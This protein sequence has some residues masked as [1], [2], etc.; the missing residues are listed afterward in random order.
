MAQKKSTLWM[1][2][3]PLF[4]SPPQITFADRVEVQPQSVRLVR[5][6]KFLSREK[7][8]V[9]ANGE[10]L[11]TF[12]I[13]EGD[14]KYPSLEHIKNFFEL[15]IKDAVKAD[16]PIVIEKRSR[17]L[18]NDVVED[19]LGPKNPNYQHSLRIQNGFYVAPHRIKVTQ[20]KK[21]NAVTVRIDGLE[22]FRRE[23]G[24]LGTYEINDKELVSLYKAMLSVVEHATSENTLVEVGLVSHIWSFGSLLNPLLLSDR[25]VLT[26]SQIMALQRQ[27]LIARRLEIV[28]RLKRIDANLDR[29]DK[30]G[31]VGSAGL[32]RRD[33]A[34]RKTLVQHLK[35]LDAK[36]DALE[37]KQAEEKESDETRRHSTGY[38]EKQ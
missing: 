25:P 35:D 3:T 9:I 27:T 31:L 26:D 13:G 36:L 18:G 33:Q 34:D 23:K 37:A 16:V 30:R 12:Q 38:R 11:R 6:K 14:N 24:K 28:D 20:E 10:T 15:K 4:F 21:K 5:S 32:F 8:E 1:L 29:V 22:V 7:L 17:T 19:E 2:I